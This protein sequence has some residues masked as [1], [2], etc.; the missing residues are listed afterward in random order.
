[1]V[2]VSLGYPNNQDGHYRACLSKWVRNVCKSTWC[3]WLVLPVNIVVASWQ[4]KCVY[5]L[6]VAISVSGM[7]GVVTSTLRFYTPIV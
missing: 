6:S 3:Q 5:G 4:Y 1:M 2:R 7:N